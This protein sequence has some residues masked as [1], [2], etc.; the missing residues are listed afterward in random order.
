MATRGDLFRAPLLLLAGI[1]TTGNELERAEKPE[2]ERKAGTTRKA[3]ER[4]KG[5]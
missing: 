5:P 2:N 4:P 1:G 3:I